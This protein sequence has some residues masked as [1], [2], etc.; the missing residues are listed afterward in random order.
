LAS[1]PNVEFSVYK[2]AAPPRSMEGTLAVVCS[3]SGETEET[4]GMLKTAVDNDA[5][6]V[7]MSSG[8]TL[9]RLAE[10]H[11]LPHIR[12]PKVVAPRYMLPFIV[13]SSLAVFE[14]GFA[15]NCAGEA[16]EA[17]SMMEEEGA[18]VSPDQGEPGNGAKTIAA[19]LTDK[20][21][22]VYGGRLLEGVAARFKNVLNENAKVHAVFDEI[23]DVFHN[24]IESW[25]DERTDFLPIFL[26]HSGEGALDRRKSDRMFRLLSD[27]GFGPLQIRGRGS[28]SLAQMMSM[29]FRL[30][31]ASYYLAIA[32]GRDPFPTRLIDRLKRG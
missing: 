26:R 1:Y 25:E 14:A 16:E 30:D 6:I 9:M 13:F 19:A 31:M 3:A 29:V 7:C 15:L 4:I 18:H 2:G 8:G 12:M 11:G 24:E 23:P 27:D 10:E 21:A 20:T 32:L 28:S 5:T 17:I 22:S